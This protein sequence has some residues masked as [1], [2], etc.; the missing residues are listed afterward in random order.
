M[1]S[2]K[3]LSEVLRYARRNWKGIQRSQEFQRKLDSAVGLFPEVV[4]HDAKM[5]RGI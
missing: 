1:Q 4:S 2:I 5:R 3:R